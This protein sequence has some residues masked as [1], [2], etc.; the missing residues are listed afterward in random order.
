[1]KRY[2]QT[3]TPVTTALLLLSSSL[4]IAKDQEPWLVHAK[5]FPAPSAYAEAAIELRLLP[6][7]PSL[8]L[9]FADADRCI[10]SDD[11]VSCDVT[12]NVTL[13]PGQYTIEAREVLCSSASA[14]TARLSVALDPHLR[15]NEI[16]VFLE[17][18]DTGPR[19][20]YLEIRADR[21]ANHLLVASQDDDRLAVVDP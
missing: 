17:T 9:P 14:V 2:R 7:G 13:K 20:R 11:G 21:D 1:M 8:L 3:A 18:E 19:L 4:C 6:E 10:V 12:W 16:W 15:R 5:T